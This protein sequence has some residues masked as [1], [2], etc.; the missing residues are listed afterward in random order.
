MRSSHGGGVTD[1]HVILDQP[2][3]EKLIGKGDGLFRPSWANGP[4]RVQSAFVTEDEVA[5]VVA[6]C[7]AELAA[8]YGAIDDSLVDLLGRATELIV[9]TQW[10]STSMIQRKH[11]VGLAEAGRLMDLLQG[12]GI[13]GPSK[14]A[15]T[16]DVLLQPTQLETAIARVRG[17][18]L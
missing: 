13:V 9:V 12:Y 6:H 7:K 16:R 5:A 17:A 18:G 15:E 10:G 1:S 8:W 14:G 3:A 11:G 4:I 2:G